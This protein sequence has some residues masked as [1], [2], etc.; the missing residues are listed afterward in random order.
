TAFTD[1]FSLV[2]ENVLSFAFGTAT[3]KSGESGEKRS[4]C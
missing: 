2:C 4:F 3:K 1:P